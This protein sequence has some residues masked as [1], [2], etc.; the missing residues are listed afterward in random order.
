[1]MTLSEVGDADGLDEG[2]GDGGLHDVFQQ[3]RYRHEHCICP[4]RV[5]ESA[6]HQH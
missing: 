3:V 1:M 4:W 5:S 2:L 6:D